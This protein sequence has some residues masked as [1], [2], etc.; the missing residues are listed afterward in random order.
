MDDV[1]LD[2]IRSAA[3]A[4][5]LVVGAL[6]GSSIR[7]F[8]TENPNVLAVTFTIEHALED[9]RS[10]ARTEVRAVAEGDCLLSE[11]Q[12]LELRMSSVILNW[13]EPTGEPGRARSVFAQVDSAHLG[14][15]HDSYIVRHVIYEPPST[16]SENRPSRADPR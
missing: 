4:Q 8:A 5:D 11:G 6:S 9:I 3:A 1:T 7:V 12:A 10:P 2:N 15:R 13:V 16:S 14:E